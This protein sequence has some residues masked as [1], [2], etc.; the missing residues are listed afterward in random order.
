[1]RFLREVLTGMRRL[2]DNPT[3]DPQ[4]GIDDPIDDPVLDP[5]TD[6]EL[7]HVVD[8]VSEDPDRQGMIRTVKG[9]HLVYKR[10]GDEGSFEELWVY[11]VADFR[12]QQD[13]KRAIL[14]GTD[15]PVNRTQSPDGAQSY[16]IWAMGN[17]EM[18]LIRGLPS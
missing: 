6:Q 16:E 14:A 12:G 3:P 5:E 17:V 7:D 18:I 11:N 4:T 8:E 10:E 9:A 13:V 2:D 15:I 1:M